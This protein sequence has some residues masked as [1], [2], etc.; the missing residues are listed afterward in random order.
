MSNGTPTWPPSW[1]VQDAQSVE[2]SRSSLIEISGHIHGCLRSLHGIV[3]CVDDFFASHFPASTVEILLTDLINATSS[4]L[5]VYFDFSISFAAAHLE[6]CRINRVVRAAEFCGEKSSSLHKAVLIAS[7]NIQNPL[8]NR[9]I[10]EQKESASLL[11]HWRVALEE[12]ARKYQFDRNEVESMLEL[13]LA[14]AIAANELT[15]PFSNGGGSNG[16]VPTESA[17][18]IDDE[19]HVTDEADGNKRKVFLDPSVAKDVKTMANFFAMG[20][21]SLNVAARKAAVVHSGN[22][23]SIKTRFYRFEGDG[24]ISFDPPRPTKGGNNGNT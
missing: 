5:A 17:D 9:L 15:G 4:A 1:A 7:L 16:Q 22:W 23:K 21:L 18:V 12:L 8:R 10:A 24:K 2:I 6:L 11:D 19:G 13:E 14:Q 3:Y 20:G